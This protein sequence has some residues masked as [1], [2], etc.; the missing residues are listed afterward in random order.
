MCLLDS[1]GIVKYVLDKTDPVKMITE[2]L[3]LVDDGVLNV[4]PA[5]LKSLTLKQT[6]YG[7]EKIEEAENSLE[8]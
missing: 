8:F 5:K 4:E 1:F 7:I 2:R 3:G 6:A